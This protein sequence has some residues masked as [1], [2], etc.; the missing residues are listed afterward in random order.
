[1][2]R[3]YPIVFERE[4]S[5]AISVY[6]QGLP[7]YAAA[8]SKHP[9]KPDQHGRTAGSVVAPES[10]GTAEGGDRRGSPRAHGTN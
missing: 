8:D 6:V 7:V 5:G 10:D 4:D 1:M 3:D 9:E 2:T